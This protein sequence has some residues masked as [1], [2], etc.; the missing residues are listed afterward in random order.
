[1]FDQ[2]LKALW[3]EMVRVQRVAGLWYILTC[4][5]QNWRRNVKARIFVMT[6]RDNYSESPT[7]TSTAVA[8]ALGK[9]PNDAQ[10]DDWA[11]QYINISYLQSIMEAFDDDGS[12]YVT[13]TEVNRF[14]DM[15]PPSLGWRCVD[16]VKSILLLI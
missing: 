8:D 5:S 3:K 12:G 15:L 4:E 13:V 9:D 7:R 10:R 11:F 6:L 14:I 16:I 2:E 1:M